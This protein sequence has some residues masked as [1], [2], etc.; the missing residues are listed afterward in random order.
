MTLAPH[1]ND[2]CACGDYRRQHNGEHGDGACGMNMLGHG[3]A[4]ACEAFRLATPGRDASPDF[5]DRGAARNAGY[6]A[7]RRAHAERTGRPISTA[8]RGSAITRTSD[9]G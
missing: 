8:G 3:G 9:H 7:A 2:L 4:P 5:V 1:D 6:V